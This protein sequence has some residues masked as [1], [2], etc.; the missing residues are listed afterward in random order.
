LTLLHL[1][2][3]LVA[4]RF[5]R[6]NV[7]CRNLANETAQVHH[8]A[9][10]VVVLVDE[11]LASMP[12]GVGL[13]ASVR[14]PT[15]EDQHE[16]LAALTNMW[17]FAQYLDDRTRRCPRQR[18]RLAEYADALYEAVQTLTQTLDALTIS[19]ARPWG[20]ARQFSPPARAAAPR[21]TERSA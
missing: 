15:G 4:R 18:A 14:I 17:G 3:Q 12:R 1:R 10:R 2:T 11:L 9:A 21:D 6:G 16:V 13:A 19:E 7:P 20:E 8:A 5:R